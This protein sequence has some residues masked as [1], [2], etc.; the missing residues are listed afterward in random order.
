MSLSV[1]EKIACVVA[2]LCGNLIAWVTFGPGAPGSY[3]S[4]IPGPKEAAFGDIVSIITIF[5][6]LGLL[7]YIADYIYHL[8]PPCD[9]M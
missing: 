1:M 9:L 6:D 3:F 5:V 8:L 7:V 4:N 2:F